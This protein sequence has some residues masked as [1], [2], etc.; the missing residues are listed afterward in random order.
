MPAG[1]MS[2]QSS[3]DN[4]KYFANWEVV[5]LGHLL[6]NSYSLKPHGQCHYY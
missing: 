6:L 5:K 2:L 3:P 1:Y 4:I